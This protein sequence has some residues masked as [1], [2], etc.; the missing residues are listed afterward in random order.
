MATVYEYDTLTEEQK[1]ACLAE[2]L[3][4]LNALVDSV[5]TWARESGWVTRRIEKTMDDP[6]LGRYQAPALLMQELFARVL[7]E[8]G[9]R[10]LM[11]VDGGGAE[12]YLMPEYDDVARLYQDGDRWYVEHRFAGMDATPRD[13]VSKPFTKEVFMEILRRMNDHAAQVG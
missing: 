12:L 9:S 1:P 7:L 6:P 4:R 13:D 5:E 2:W 11:G 3:Q 8:P 10:F